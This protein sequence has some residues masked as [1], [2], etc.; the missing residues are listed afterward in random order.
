LSECHEGSATI[1]DEPE[2]NLVCSETA[3]DAP[4]NALTKIEAIRRGH[5]VRVDQQGFS[6]QETYNNPQ[7]LA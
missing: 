2:N 7:D 4:V 6:I 3:H 5:G 1:A